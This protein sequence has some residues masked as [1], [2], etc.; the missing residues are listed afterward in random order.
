MNFKNLI[1]IPVVGTIIE[2]EKNGKTY[3]LMQTRR[4]PWTPYHETLET[5]VWRI[6][7]RENIYQALQREVKE[8]TNLDITHINTQRNFTP[9]LDAGLTNDTTIGY[10][11]R[12]CTQQLKDGLPWMMFGFVCKC[13]W[14]CKQ[15][16]EETRNP[17]WVSIEELE[18][19]MIH[20]KIFA[21]QKPFLE[22]YLTY[23]KEI[24][25]QKFIL[26]RP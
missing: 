10:S 9:S 13:T 7:Q 18:Y 17:R 22:Y 1:N 12:Y 8:E 14:T 23:R 6:K 16:E 26:D 19:M 3:I 11:P 21:L 5:P 25:F 15:Q 4:K 20:G 24:T 2:K